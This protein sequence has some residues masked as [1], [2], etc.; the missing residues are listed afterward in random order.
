MKYYSSGLLG[1]LAIGKKHL[2]LKTMSNFYFLLT[3][4]HLKRYRSISYN[5]LQI[6]EGKDLETENLT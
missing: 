5:V 6:S 3:E 1:W 2:T 4:F